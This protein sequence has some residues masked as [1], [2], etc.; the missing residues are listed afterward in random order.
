MKRA[1]L[2]LVLASCSK[3]IGIGDVTLNGDAGGD[4]LP[5]PPANTVI[6]KSF[7][8][9]VTATGMADTPVDQSATIIQ[10]LLP[11][12][13]EPTG[14]RVVSG[15]GQADGTFRIDNVPDGMEYVLKI[16]KQYF[17][18]TVHS[19]EQRF[20]IPQRCAPAPAVASSPTP[21]TFNIGGMQTFQSGPDGVFDSIEIDSFNLLYQ[22]QTETS[23]GASTFAKAFDW[24]T[25]GGNFFNGTKPLPDASAMDD[26][27]VQHLRTD[28]ITS[29]AKR[30]HS[31]THLVDILQ[32]TDV[33]L[34]NGTPAA[35]NGTF[36]QATANKSVLFSVTRGS[37]DSLFDPLTEQPSLSVTLLAQPV[38]INFGLGTLAGVSFDDWSRSTSL[39]ESVTV[40]YAD[41]MPASWQRMIT[42]VYDR[43]RLMLLPNTTI[44]ILL[45]SGHS[46]TFA[47][48]GGTPSLSPTMAAPTNVVFGGADAAAGGKLMFDGVK[49]VTV[50]WNAVGSAKVYRLLVFRLFANGAQTRFGTQAIMVTTK[51]SVDIPAEVFSGS[52]FFYFILDAVQ[53]PADYASGALIA[54]G[55][56]EQIAGFSSG[57]FRLSAKCGNGAVDTGEECDTSGESATCDVDCTLRKCGDG[58]RNA[59]AGE[60]C[61]TVFETPG[62]DADCTAAVCGDGVV[63]RQALEDCDDGN[64]VDNGNG[65]SAGCK[66][67]N[68]CG[69][70]VVQAQAEQ[71]DSSGVDSASCD[72]DCTVPDC[73]DGHRNA[74]AGE[75]CDDG[76]FDDGDGCKSDCTP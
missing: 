26:L 5:P 27:T 29:G 63:N 52:E 11:D 68:V 53:T 19:V 35:I 56:P 55:L 16:G 7:N 60:A 59:A 49:P 43:R 38:A 58:L 69:N 51:T 12:A 23:N 21:V 17:V 31:F 9:C 45:G 1:G 72:F 76:N 65:C 14:F 3:I 62:C 24:S 57:M 73:P 15:S 47:F 34:T 40:N 33:T 8:R 75:A 2:L 25:Q 4:G 10:A 36:V 48:T 22:G 61:D 30:K 44:P 71:C 6:G 37:F 46:R 66:F 74:A 42:V 13:A 64:T 32:R 67:N 20:D 28:Q 18:T 50:A 70:G 54:N 39:T 41:P